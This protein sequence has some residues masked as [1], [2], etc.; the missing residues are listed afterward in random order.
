MRAPTTSNPT[1]VIYQALMN[2]LN[3]DSTGA[4][5]SAPKPHVFNFI[6][7]DACCK[8]AQLFH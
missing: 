6:Q 5:T 1:P 8:N 4:A 7:V 3:F 2:L